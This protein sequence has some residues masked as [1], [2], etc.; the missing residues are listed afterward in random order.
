MS[1]QGIQLEAAPRRLS[2]E[3]AVCARIQSRYAGLPFTIGN[4]VTF[5]TSVRVPFYD[6]DNRI[7]ERPAGPEEGRR[8]LRFV[9]RLN[10]GRGP[11][12]GNVR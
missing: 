6:N 9:H 3:S 8:V 5:G 7:D 11:R 4:A 1:V 12:P 2:Y 10:P